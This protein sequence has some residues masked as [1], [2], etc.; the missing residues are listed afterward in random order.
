VLIEQ[1]EVYF[2]VRLPAG[3]ALHPASSLRVIVDSVAIRVVRMFKLPGLQ[4]GLTILLQEGY[5]ATAA[6]VVLH[7]QQKERRRICRRIHVR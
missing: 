7:G 4:H 1:R 6:H 5:I 2:L 3:P